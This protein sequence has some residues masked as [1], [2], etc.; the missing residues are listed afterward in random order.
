VIS[1]S[2]RRLNVF[3]TAVDLGG[4]NVAA[5]RLGIAQPSV[6]AHIKA[7]ERQ[8]GQPLFH[9]RRGARPRLTKAGETLY[10][11]AVDVLRKSEEMSAA[12]SHLRST[13]QRDITIAAQRDIAQNFLPRHLTA[14]ARRHP[15]MRFVTHTG[16]IE[17]VLRL[18]RDGAVDLGLYGALGPEPGVRTRQLAREPFVFVVSPRHPLAGRRAIAPRE[19][20]RHPFVTGLRSSRHFAMLDSILK[21]M[22]VASYTVAMEAQD[23]AAVRE[24]A[25]HGAGIAGMLQ[26]CV[27]EEIQAGALV[28][29]DLATPPVELQIR[30]AYHAPL[31]ATA[32][33]FVADL[34]ATGTQVR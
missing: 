25:R 28:A 4:F 21:R 19:L 7:L 31:S 16:T 9:R 10:A 11:F 3:K 33:D 14:Y 26:F 23:F 24:L 1:A 13:G 20:E 30:C 5:D 6:G 8:V 22:G 2:P 32:R 27:E 12:L 34:K 15:E 18:V 29:L 17:D